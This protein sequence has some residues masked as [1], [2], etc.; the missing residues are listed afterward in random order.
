MNR[1]FGIDIGSTFITVFEKQTGAVIRTRHGGKI[2][3][4]LNEIL[5]GINN[6][7]TLVFTGKAGKEIAEKLNGL[8]LDEAAAISC[9]LSG[10]NPFTKMSSPGKEKR[11]IIDIGASSLTLY[12]INDNRVA[13]ITRNTLCAA[14]TG[15]FLEEQAE[16]LD[17]DLEKAKDLDVKDPPLIA[18][19]CTV[20]A[21]SDLIHHQQ[22]GRSKN[23]MWAGL[24]RSLVV[25]AT[26]TLFRGREPKGKILLCGGV[27]LNREVIK[28][29]R[30]LYKNAEWIVPTNSEAITAAGAA[31]TTG[32]VKEELTL[33]NET[34]QKEFAK[35]PPL[36]LKRSTYPEMPEPTI[37]DHQNE[38]RIH[39]DLKK[40]KRVILG[41]DIGSTSTK[42]AVLDADDKQPL[43]DIYGRTAGDPV[44]AARNIFASFYETLD[45][46]QQEESKDGAEKGCEKGDRQEKAEVKKGDRQQEIRDKRE[47]IVEAFGTT[48]S[49]RYL[50][51]K[52]FGAG[53]IVN[54]ITAHGRGTG[55]F[56]PDVETIFEIGGQ[57]AKYIR[58]HDGFTADV[59]MNYVC[60]AGTGSFVEE[61]ARKLD[62]KLEEIG[63]ITTGIAPPVTA[64]RC[65]VFMEQD[66]RM[67][68]KEGF[69]REEALASVLYSV[70][71]NYLTR[72]VGNR[73]I[74]NKKIFFQG[75]TARNKGLVAALENLLKVEV[76]VSPFCHLM[77]AVGAAII[78]QEAQRETVLE[79]DCFPTTDEMQQAQSKKKQLP[80]INMATDFPG[81]SAVHLEVSSRMDTCKLCRNFCR[82]NYVSRAGGSE[83]SWGYQCGRDPLEQS[84]KEIAQFDLFGQRDRLFLRKKTEHSPTPAKGTITIIN[85]LFNHTFYPLWQ[86]F[87]NRLGYNVRLSSRQ[88]GTDIKK[89]SAAVAS[90]DFC[91]PFKTVLGH[92]VKALEKPDPMFLPYMIADKS[93]MKTAF[94]FFCPYMQSSASI[95]RSA[96]QRN[97]VSTESLVS[98]VIDLRKPIKETAVDI[99]Q[100][101]RGSLDVKKKAVITA[102]KKAFSNWEKATEDLQR[103]GSNLLKTLAGTDE[104]VFILIGRPYNLYDRGLNLGIPEKIASMGYRVIPLDMLDLDD[105]IRALVNSNYHNIFWKYGQKIIAALRK[106]YKADNIFPI[107]LSNFNC[108]PDS[109]LLSF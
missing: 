14:G 35:M 98:P 92:V 73:K 78:A 30:E 22:E 87:F 71:K 39:G 102:F 100:S 81:R 2:Q 17:M 69:S 28:W 47:V 83:F 41:M 8:Y 19:R 56:F 48:G 68:L 82:I 16:R 34:E 46:L 32:R 45:A 40:M 6:G 89:Y 86:E 49:G 66:L 61:Q 51:G 29:F 70:I 95:V 80:D 91:F 38:I 63:D 77:G 106:A 90:A 33:S 93:L 24:C 88:T 72:V 31:S 53:S 97:G 52:I 108:G 55:H 1:T 7:D 36:E 44:N 13:D 11:E 96:L 60:A 109:F 107:Y 74:N 50:V 3:A 27:S 101:L 105:E 57:D 64:D 84:R 76:V 26:N 85:A 59:N 23:E 18:S 94:A 75:A 9:Y 54:E 79:S 58:L 15:L 4:V 5:H 12:T 99:F 42:L 62:F 21:K 10:D 65:T 25:S 103:S 20:F 37:D 43:L 67:L 104:P